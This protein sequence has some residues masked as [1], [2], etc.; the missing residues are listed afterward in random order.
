MSADVPAL[1]SDTP[2]QPL[3]NKFRITVNLATTVVAVIAI[4]GLL[5]YIPG[6]RSLGSLGPDYIPMAYTAA[7]CFLIFSASLYHHTRKFSYRFSSIPTNTLVLL[8]TLF[9]VTEISELFFGMDLNFS[10]KLFP[11]TGMLGSI[12]IGRMSPA[13]AAT[14]SIAGA[15][16]LLISLRGRSSR[17]RRQLGNGASSLGALTMLIGATVLLAYLYGTP[18]MYSGASVPMAATSALAFLFLGVALVVSTGPDNFLMCRISGDSTA[19]LLSRLFLSLTVTTVLLQS[20]LLHFVVTTRLVNE[21]LIIAVLVIVIGILTAFVVDYVAGLTGNNIDEVNR[22]LVDTLHDLQKSEQLH[23]TV[24]ETAM[25]GFWIITLQGHL[26][27]VNEAY[28]RISGYNRQELLSMSI[29]DLET[30]ETPEETMAHIQMLV[31]TG[32]SR[33]ETKHRHKNGNLIEIEISAQFQSIEEGR[34]VAFLRNIDG[35][36]QAEL[37]LKEAWLEVQRFR[38]AL[39]QVSSHIYMKDLHSHYIYANRSTLELFSCSAEELAGCDDFRFFPADTALRLREID[40]RVYTGQQSYEEINF[41]DFEG[42][43]RVYLEVKTPVYNLPDRET[44]VGLLGIST[45]ITEHKH[46]EE[47]LKKKNSEI[48]QFLYTVSHD[49]R[50]PLVTIKTFMG[51]IEKD[52]VENNHERLAQDMQF[53]HGAADKMKLLLD[54]LLDFYRIDRVTAPPVRISLLEVLSETLDTLAGDISA[55][56]VDI[57]L[58]DQDLIL[59][60]ERPR[61]AQIWQNLI[62]NAIKYSREGSIILRIEVGLLQE[63]AETVFF[64]KDNGIGIDP[65]YHG[66]IFELFDKLDPKSPGAGLGLSMIQRIVEKFGGRVWVESEGLGKGSCFFFTLPSAMVYD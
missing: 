60:G 58:P 4:N 61:I 27:E 10:N 44:V 7:V 33:Y 43:Q 35:R 41:V 20:F 64:V 16:I 55:R 54:E 6:L 48:E 13:T 34:I 22:K 31:A 23:R 18:F 51:Y 63:N 53:I 21:A 36:K 26:L 19:A 57:R 56:K 62:E 59:Y 38:E 24:L 40:A 32:E 5:G 17:H 65:Q 12:P 2:E 47:E 15:G 46:I 37:K 66:K 39:D 1:R 28:C 11:P 52:L 14:F 45:D 49:L 30:N 25:D 42:R 9:C 8:A 3:G 29:F 50:S